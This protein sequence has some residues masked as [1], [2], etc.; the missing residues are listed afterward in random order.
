MNNARSNHSYIG[1]S[2]C[3]LVLNG[4][5]GSSPYY[6]NTTEEFDGTNYSSGPNTLLCLRGTA[7]GG[8]FT[9]GLSYGGYNPTYPVGYYNSQRWDGVSFAF[10]NPTTYAYKAG[11][12]NATPGGAI[13]AFY[14]GGYA[15]A[16][17]YGGA[18][19]TQIASCCSLTLCSILPVWSGGGALITSRD[20]ACASGTQNAGIIASGYRSTPGAATTTTEEFDGNVWASGGAV[21][22]GRYY[23]GG[24]SQGTQNATWIAGGYSTGDTNL[25]EEYNGS[26]WSAGNVIITTRRPTGTGTLTAGLIFGG[27]A[28]PSV[29]SCTEEY[30]GTN[31]ASS[32]NMITA[33]TY[34]GAAGTQN[35]TVTTGGV[36]PGP[37]NSTEEYNG[38]SW[39]SAGNLLASYGYLSGFGT[40]NDA[41]VV[42]GYS[43]P[44]QRCDV[45]SYD[46]VSWGY[47]PFLL[48]KRYFPGTGG[49]TT[50]A[51]A[52]GGG[53][54]TSMTNTELFNCTTSTCIGAWSFGTKMN[55][56]RGYLVGAGTSQNAA[57][58]FGG[59]TPTSQ[60]ATE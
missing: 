34:M 57:L 38:T 42:G 41:T 13:G 56:A 10:D 28:T 25:T 44:N 60:T 22:T 16:S 12:G 2:D 18:N 32:N 46:G 9:D 43:A 14:A 20:S 36:S 11:M 7:V 48:K 31:W 59:M 26:S 29:K 45:Y 52:A 54:P 6:T 40:Q 3:G 33:R 39:S 21:I 17:P 4:S 24:S 50:A 1:T 35:A 53:E 51:F 23:F 55:T 58:A 49:T 37:Q 15:P 19:T 8:T 47:L 5:P 27:Y 30:D